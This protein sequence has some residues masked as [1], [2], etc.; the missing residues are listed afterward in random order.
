MEGRAALVAKVTPTRDAFP[1]PFPPAAAE[2]EE[3]WGGSL[4]VLDTSTLLNLYSLADEAREEVFRL[5]GLMAERLWLPRHVGTEFFRGR[6]GVIERERRRCLEVRQSLLRPLTE[7]EDRRRHPFVAPP[8]VE[9]L[10]RVREELAEAMKPL[11]ERLT[12]W[13]VDDPVRDRLADLFAGRVGAELPEEAEATL[14]HEAEERAD[15]ERPPGYLDYLDKDKK[16]AAGDRRWGDLKIWLQV[17]EQAQRDKRH[18]VLVTDERKKDWWLH[19]ERW[20][21]PE[22]GTRE[23]NARELLSPR[24]ELVREYAGW[25]GGKRLVLASLDGFIAEAS[26]RSQGD[27]AQKEAAAEA[28]EQAK[29]ARDA[30]E[31]IDRTSS[32]A[33]P[34]DVGVAIATALKVADCW[35]VA[36]ATSPRRWC[37]YPSWRIATPDRR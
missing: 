29:R 34:L 25:T 15:A 5:L 26:E 12:A 1:E 13:L 14:S 36:L 23:L 35:R 27:A 22:N 21:P 19:T 17:R 11:E 8:L 3:V 31:L 24:P 33:R 18:L 37:G 30:G 16:D 28:A 32:A 2:L 20:P 9:E 4:I 10:R 6:Q 7:V